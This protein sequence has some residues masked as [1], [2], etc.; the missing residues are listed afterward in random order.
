MTFV[1]LA[2][3]NAAALGL[4]CRSWCDT[5]QS[6]QEFAARDLQVEEVLSR[7]HLP[8]VC[9]TGGEP[10]LQLY[11]VTELVEAAHRAGIRVHI[12]TNGTVSPPRG[13][14]GRVLSSLLEDTAPRIVGKDLGERGS[15]GLFDWVVV[16]P[17]PPAYVIADGWEGLVDEL[18]LV[19]DEGLDVATAE[20]LAGSHPEA[21]VSIQPLAGVEG[22]EAVRGAGRAGAGG[23]CDLRPMP[24]AYP[25]PPWSVERAV[26]LVASHPEWR[27]SLQVHKILGLP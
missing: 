11:S 6:W 27:L 16:S 20:R 21:L 5:P 17:K 23:P 2:G 18:K 13:H 25:A 10:L 15:R 22:G 3:C 12:E 19:V 26:A 9:L 14:A 7:V 4:G 24:G 8:R 1:R